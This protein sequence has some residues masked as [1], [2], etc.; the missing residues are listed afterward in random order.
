MASVLIA[1]DGSGSTGGN[2]AYHSE[3]QRIVA[4]YPDATILFWDSDHRIITADELAE[5]NR[6]CKGFDGTSPNEIATW[7]RANNFH[8]RLVIITDGEVYASHVDVCSTTLGEW[9]FEY[10]EAHLIGGHVNMSVTCPFTRMSPHSV[11]LYEPSTGHQRVLTTAVSADDLGLLTKLGSISTID[12]FQIVA[13]TLESVL[14]A[15]TMGT[16]GNMELRDALL[17]M[18]K[19][20]NSTIAA[21][22]GE[23][24]SAKEFVAALDAHQYDSAITAARRLTSEYYA[25]FD[26][27]DV[28]GSTWSSKVSRMIAMTEGALRGVFSMNDITAGIQ[29]DRIR[30]AAVAPA[31]DIPAAAAA[32]SHEAQPQAQFV[33]PITL[34]AEHDVVLLVKAGEPILTGVEKHVLD[35]VL[36]C[37]LNLMKYPELV[38]ALVARLDHPMSLAAY[39]AKEAVWTHSPMTRDPVL[40]GAICFGAAADH[41]KAT[42]WTLAQLCTGGKLSG[43]PDFW[44]ACVWWVLTHTHTCP[45]YLESL[46]P[47]ADAH[48]VWRLQNQSSFIALSG[49]PEFPTTRVPLRSAIWYVLSSPLFAEEAGAGASRDVLRGHIPHLTPLLELYALAGFTIPE[50]LTRHYARL[51]T[52]LRYLAWIKKDALALPMWTRMLVQAH[53]A[54]DDPKYVPVDGPAASNQVEEARKHLRADPMLTIEE[55]VGLAGMV[56]PQKSAADI[57]LSLQWTPPSPVTHVM[58]WPYGLGP[59]EP[60]RLTIH[61]K[62]CRPQYMYGG[63]TW[64]EIS[65]RKYGPVEH[66]ISVN[67]AYGKYVEAHGAYPSRNDL[68]VYLYKRCVVHGCHTTLPAAILQFIDEVCADYAG[69]VAS[70]PP[71]EFIKRWRESVSIQD[72]LRIE[73]AP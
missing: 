23:S 10:V 35:D 41:A 30:R 33:C 19:R 53:I 36:D 57:P 20:I 24:D 58:E 70:M 34:D 66:Q 47:F 11:Y 27:S 59:Q 5:I 13:A 28:S 6:K 29:S 21:A 67:A 32:P 12:E 14:V 65:A 1:Y 37:P 55:L 22:A 3:T 38:E 63:E 68:L 60:I 39:G 25:Q 16:H 15:R 7:V 44:Y 50:A 61:P 9:A 42:Q 51:R 18:K 72:R 45:P 49:L 48:M 31:A 69:I 4:Q 54:A 43:N 64:R 62:T 2:A 8:G 52:L 71:A 73:G 40:G 26:E 17:A 56:S 46:K